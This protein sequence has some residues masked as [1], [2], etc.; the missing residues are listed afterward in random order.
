MFWVE[1][2]LFLTLFVV[3]ANC[4]VVYNLSTITHECLNNR[5]IAGDYTLL[6]KVINIGDLPV[7]EYEAPNNVNRKRMLIAGYDVHGFSYSNLK[8]VVDQMAVQNG[9]FRAIL[10]DYFRG[11]DW[12]PNID[13]NDRP[14]WL[15][16]VGDWESV[17]KPD[18]I[19]IVSHYKN[20]GVEEFGI[21]GMCFGGKVATLASIHL[22]DLFKASALI[23]PSLVTNDEAFD[24]KV[25]M[26]LMPAMSD[27]DMLPFYEV[28]KGKFG[29]NTGHRRFD[30][31]VHGFSGAHS[32]FSEP[33][34]QERVNEVITTLGA[35]FDRNLNET[36]MDGNNA[37]N[38]L[39]C[40]LLIMTLITAAFV[41]R[42]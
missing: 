13:I 40:H 23:H 33:L 30:D 25:P 39:P 34:I 19:N 12:F 8:H 16:R 37:H 24:V 1:L 38:I 2:A 28:L 9:G 21:Y 7:Y 31:M 5:A 32:N 18:L 20:E 26:Y 29:D 3:S 15:A 14:E 17:V 35:F 4:N 41:I 36:K 42:K 11:D 10:P 6:G 22:S 27:L